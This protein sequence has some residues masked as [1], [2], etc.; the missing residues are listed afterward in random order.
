MLCCVEGRVFSLSMFWRLTGIGFL[1]KFVI[2][3]FWRVARDLL[4]STWRTEY[5]SLAFPLSLSDFT[6]TESPGISSG[7]ST[8]G[9]PQDLY[10]AE[11][12]SVDW[13]LENWRL[14]RELSLRSSWH[15]ERLSL[16][17]HSSLADLPE[18]LIKL[19]KLS[20]AL[21]SVRDENGPP[22]G[23]ILTSC[24]LSSLMAL[25]AG[26]LLLTFLG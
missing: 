9:A 7:S 20:V 5:V 11:G 4:W 15:P 8:S 21:A 2:G 26:L 25:S 14:D 23:E 3:N 1:R 18:C 13:R 10:Q 12:R 19:F 24:S 16:H 17:I 6:K 22:C